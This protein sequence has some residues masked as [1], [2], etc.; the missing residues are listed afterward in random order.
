MKVQKTLTEA[1]PR[2]R[3]CRLTYLVL[4]PDE[5]PDVVPPAPAESPG[6]DLP[7][8]LVALLVHVVSQ[9]QRREEVVPEE[10]CQSNELRCKAIEVQWI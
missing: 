9:V 10:Q 7:L 8:V 1:E 4:G 2:R 6:Q 5:M 3:S